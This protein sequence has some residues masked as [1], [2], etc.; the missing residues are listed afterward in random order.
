MSQTEKP[1]LFVLTSHGAKGDSGQPT[2]FYL[3]EATRD[4]LAA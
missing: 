3:G 1:V 4:L 2:G